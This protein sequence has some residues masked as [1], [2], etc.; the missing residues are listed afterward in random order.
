MNLGEQL[1]EYTRW[2][3]SMATAIDNYQCWLDDAGLCDT[4]TEML[5][6]KNLRLLE[7]DNITIAF[8][9][10]FSRGKTELI[11]AL[12]FASTGVRLLPSSPGRTTMCPTEL[13]YD[14][15]EKP[16]LRL[17]D[18]DTRLNENP[19]ED[20]KKDPKQWTHIELDCDS[21]KQMQEAFLQLLKTKTVSADRA[22]QLGLDCTSG[23]KQVSI[24]QWRHA[25]VSFPHPLLEKGL[26]ILDTPGLNAL[27][28]EPELTL[29]M[30]PKAQAMI[31]VLAADTGVTQSDMHMWEHHINAYRS[32]HPHGLAVVL[33]KIDTLNDELMTEDEW[34]QSIHK[35]TLETA[36]LLKLDEQSIFPLSAK[37]ALIAKIK[38]DDEALSTSRL[39]ALENFLSDR[40]LSSQKDILQ[41]M[42]VDDV[43]GNMEQMVNTLSTQVKNIVRH[44]GELHNICSQSENA[45]VELLRLTRKEQTIYNKNL[46]HLKT[47]RHIFNSQITDLLQVVNPIK[48]KGIFNDGREKIVQSW[49]SVGIRH[50]MQHAFDELTFLLNETLMTTQASTNLLNTIYKKFKD[51]H[52]LDV[53]QPSALNFEVYQGRLDQLLREGLEFSH[54][55]NAALTGQNTLAKRFV[56]TIGGQAVAIFE[57]AQADINSWKSA[58]LAPLIREVSEQ[59]ALMESKLDSLRSVSAGK[60]ALDEKIVNNKNQ[61]ESIGVK[62]ASLQVIIDNIRCPAEPIDS[63]RVSSAGR[64]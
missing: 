27:G 43:V 50:G 56:G 36:R 62:L 16:Y 34:V 39:S 63:E 40:V 20:Y 9:A 23:D 17:L 21:P 57:Q 44:L 4:E 61:Q 64:S 37:Q 6:I 46:Q 15:K 13:F 55:S 1:H 10:E 48:V 22:K 41:H 33:N 52:D 31:F 28:S 18:I 3:K 30:L 7:K 11:N 19:I 5:L 38:Q 8:A 24:P 25:L 53:E 26:T 47:S 60:E 59:K 54:S 2:K 32:K 49:T 14:E 42:V 29:S 35:Q 12:F 45:T 51:E 58:A